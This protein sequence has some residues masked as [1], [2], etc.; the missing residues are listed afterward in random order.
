MTAWYLQNY[1]LQILWR[2]LTVVVV[3]FVLQ[4]LDP[5]PVIFHF[6]LF[7]VS[8]VLSSTLKR[9]AW[10]HKDSQEEILKG[11]RTSFRLF[12]S[13]HRSLSRQVYSFERTWRRGPALSSASRGNQHVNTALFLRIWS[14]SLKT[15]QRRETLGEFEQSPFYSTVQNNE[16]F[17]WTLG[18][19][20][21][22]RIQF[23][24][25]RFAFEIITINST[26]GPPRGNSITGQSDQC[27]LLPTL[28]CVKY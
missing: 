8:Y 15:A 28:N 16:V 18:P 20:W 3:F 10:D 5:F 4:L 14:R 27:I 21:H 9:K 26:I 13:S 24:K 25:N 6:S 23:V 2:D 1:H 22:D 7:S 12:L 19:A 17:P 11:G